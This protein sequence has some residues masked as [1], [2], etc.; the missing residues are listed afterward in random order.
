MSACLTYIGA[1]RPASP[2]AVPLMQYYGAIMESVTQ[3]QQVGGEMVTVLLIFYR[4][5]AETTS[6][7]SSDPSLADLLTHWHSLLTLVN[8]C[9]HTHTH[10]TLVYKSLGAVTH[11]PHNPI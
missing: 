8:S 6:C 4:P 11:V 2:L 1:D 3:S 9:T 5:K 10:T 7:Q